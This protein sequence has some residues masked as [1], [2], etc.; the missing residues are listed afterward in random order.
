MPVRYYC[1]ITVCPLLN[2]GEGEGVAGHLA[3]EVRVSD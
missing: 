2:Y 3:S 1:S